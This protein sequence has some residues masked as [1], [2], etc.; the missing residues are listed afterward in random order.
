MIEPKSSFI[1][2]T[3]LNGKAYDFEIPVGVGFRLLYRG[4]LTSGTK[5]TGMVRC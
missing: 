4:G 1:K 2:A 5:R 3:D